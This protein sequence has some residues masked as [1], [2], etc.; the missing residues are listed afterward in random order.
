MADTPITVTTA[1]ISIAVPDIVTSLDKAIA[2]TQADLQA[3]PQAAVL[4]LVMSLTAAGITPDGKAVGL[5]QTQ[6]TLTISVEAAATSIIGTNVDGRRGI[7]VLSGQL[8]FSPSDVNLL[9]SP[10]GRIIGVDSAIP[11]ISGSEV[12]PELV[13]HF[14]YA[15][16]A[17]AGQSVGLR[18]AIPVAVGS[19]DIGGSSVTLTLSVAP[20]LPVDKADITFAGQ[21]VALL[22][23][24]AVEVTAAS[25]DIDGID[26][27][28]QFQIAD[29]I[30]VSP[31]VFQFAGQ[32]V[33]LDNGIKF[34]ESTFTFAG[35]AVAFDQTCLV[36]QVGGEGGQYTI[37]GQEIDLSNT[38]TLGTT[39]VAEEFE[40]GGSQ[41]FLFLGSGAPTKII[42][43]F[44]SW[45]A[46]GSFSAPI[47]VADSINTQ[48][49]S[50]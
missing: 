26:V 17:F 27:E 25:F 11:T 4:A 8:T 21:D 2:V 33:T 43:A 36:E 24:W 47:V 1:A 14:D 40:L 39:V 12:V 20:I 22:Q 50:G 13:H 23:T 19:F 48:V 3:A 32:E 10:T 37:L 46:H 9:F 28:L 5:V 34:T 31:A 15:R 38:F 44:S 18:R 16:P 29:G 35:Q 7:P 6:D 49:Q 30:S 45:T 41:I 42:G